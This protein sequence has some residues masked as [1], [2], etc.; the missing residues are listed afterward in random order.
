VDVDAYDAVRSR[1]DDLVRGTAG[2]T[3]VP[4]CPAW[5]V[6]DVVAHM[7]GLCEDWVEGRLEAYASEAWTAAQVA[8]F[9]GAP[10]DVV[11]DRWRDAA[12]RF[13]ALGDD[14]A[15]GPPARWGFGDAVTHE[16]DL[17]G[18]LGAGRVPAEAV[19][20][21]VKTSIARWRQVL[22]D[23]GAPTLLLRAPDLREWW[24]GTPDDPHAL[25]GEAPAYELFRALTGR[26]SRAQVEAWAWSAGPAPVL[27]AGLPHPFAWA[28]SDII[29]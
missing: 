1:V 12:A 13:A 4:G 2:D 27:D 10:L 9:D 14:P 24:L 23:A 17:R 22:A 21:S 15:M 26:R 8:R 20:R 5:R 6:R 11:L 25:V 28:D 19:V 29:D 18:A 7:A 16:A 3:P